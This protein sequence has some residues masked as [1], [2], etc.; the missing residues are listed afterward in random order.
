MFLS[1]PNRVVTAG[2]GPFHDR[3]PLVVVAE[4][5]EVQVRAAAVG[6]G[7]DWQLAEQTAHRLRV[8]AVLCVHY[9]VLESG[10]HRDRGA[11]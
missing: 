3:D 2:F 5:R 10:T 6:L 8:P 7:A 11:R 1:A 9:G 4:E